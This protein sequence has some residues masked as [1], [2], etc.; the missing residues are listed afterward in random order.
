MYSILHRHKSIA[1]AI[2]TVASA[3]FFLWLFFTGG[4]TD[5]TAPSKRCVAEVNSGCITLRDYR[6]ELLKYSDLL[7]NPQMEALIKDQVLSN[8][9][10]QELLYQKA[11]DLSLVASD[12]EIVETIKSDPTFHEGGLFSSS[13]YKEV[14]SRVGMSPEEYEEYLRK[15]LTTQKLLRLINN[16]LYITEEELKI[17]LLADSTLL[18]G[19]LYLITPL[20][21]KAQYI[22]TDKELLEYYQKNRELFKKPETRIVWVWKEKEK[23]KA[24]ALYKDLKNGKEPQG[25]TQYLLP[26]EEAK[27]EGI[28]KGEVQRL[29][30][31][32]RAST[33]KEGDHYVVVYLKEVQPAGYEDYEKVKE[34]VKEKLIEERVQA[35]AKEKA[36]ELFKNLREGK[37]VNLRALTF[38]DTPAMQLSGILRINQEDLIKIVLSKDK[39]FGPYA[40]NQGYGVLLI[41]ERKSKEVKEEE[42]KEIA[43]DLISLKFQAVLSRYIEKLQKEAKIKINKELLGGG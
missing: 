15:L 31:Q 18:K 23:D 38:S 26:Q 34:K 29:T 17:N 7:K 22:P 37:E 1:V 43:K 5:I 6:R 8:L 41:E 36:E 10:V 25:Y 4:L 39:V 13:K 30:P 12:E 40:L 42:K 20:E 35:L 14:L 28:L 11:K 21:V 9:I 3:G 19:K 24:L 33:F 27:L 32:D 2:I 16:A